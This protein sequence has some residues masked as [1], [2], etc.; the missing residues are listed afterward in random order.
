MNDRICQLILVFSTAPFS[1]AQDPVGSHYTVPELVEV[2]D[3]VGLSFTHVS[4]ADG[5]RFIVETLGSGGGFL[6]YDND[7]WQD[8]YLVQSGPH[9]A[10]SPP[11]NR[12]FRNRG[13]GSFSEVEGSGAEDTEYGIG[14]TFGDYDNDGWTDIYVTNFGPNRL[15]RNRGN[16]TFE[17][18]SARAGVD[19]PRFSSSAAFADVNGDGWLDLYVGNYVKFTY[20]AAKPCTHRDVHVICGPDVYQAEENSFYLN[21]GNGAFQRANAV[22]G[23]V[24]A[25]PDASKTLAVLFLDADNDGDQDLY[26][27]N[28]TTANFL[29]E[30]QGRGIFSDVSLLSGTSY[31]LDGE[32][33][34]GMGIDAADIDENGLFDL[35]VSHYDDETNTLYMNEGEGM[36][37]DQSGVVGI[38]A[39]SR[40]L[41]GFGISF[42]DM[43]NSGRSDLFVANGHVSDN[44]REITPSYRYEQPNLLLLNLREAGRARFTNVSSS[45]GPALAR[46]EISRG[47][48]VSDFDRDGDQDLLVTNNNGPSRL[49][50]NRWNEGKPTHSWVQFAL[51]G[52]HCNR[53]AIGARLRLTAGSTTQER[54]VRSGSSFASQSEMVAHFGLGPEKSIT[55]V[56][57]RWPCGKTQLLE[58]PEPNRRHEIQEDRSPV[59]R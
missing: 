50:R 59:T 52:T 51:Q 35:V 19:D 7:G 20:E 40:T 45:A 58:S 46:E 34:A 8:V 23:L 15:F 24:P 28:D 11:P 1:S 16:G 14:C 57:I 25:Y 5:R 21:L 9:L 53:N 18:V 38:A 48:A 47:T 33:E 41:V 29:F 39:P 12:L 3:Q 55:R 37:T 26:V 36:F 27:A 54:E 32:A 22:H 49:L 30:N 13:D 42:F 6:D 2:Q 4:G 56:E 43:N 17:D 31:N 10:D 44:I